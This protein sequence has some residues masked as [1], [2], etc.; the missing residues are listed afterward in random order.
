[1]PGTTWIFPDEL[2]E[3]L[4][5]ASSSSSS[6]TAAGGGV[7]GAVDGPAYASEE[8]GFVGS[9]RNGY[10]DRLD[11]EEDTSLDAVSL[12]IRRNLCGVRVGGGGKGWSE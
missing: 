11:D 2:K 4:G 9:A 7:A 6:S 1:M 8:G 5:L 10:S 12:E 3:Q